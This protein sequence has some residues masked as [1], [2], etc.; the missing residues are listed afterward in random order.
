[1]AE[2]AE[3]TERTHA[4]KGGVGDDLERKLVEF[5]I[6]NSLPRAS[7]Q[8]NKQLFDL[9]RRLK[10]IPGLATAEL[11]VLR[12]IVEE[13]HGRAIPNMTTCDFLTNWGD[14]VVAWQRVKWAKGQSPLDR[15]LEDIEREPLPRCAAAYPDPRARRLVAVCRTM[16]RHAGTGPFFLSVRTA[17]DF[18]GIDPATASRWL[19]AFQADGILEL[20]TQ[21]TRGVGGKASRFRYVGGNP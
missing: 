17:G 20:V 19:V 18:V 14:F 2:Q 3:S 4:V 21:G 13:W 6:A 7:G 9:A 1:M 8:R 5:A 15:L 11:K 12:P 16:Q 10:A